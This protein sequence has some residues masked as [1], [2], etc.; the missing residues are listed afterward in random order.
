MLPK[1]L[2]L[3][4]AGI[5]CDEELAHGFRMAGAD[6]DIVHINQLVR[7]EKSIHDFDI[8]GF[9][10]GFAYGD[11]LS[12]GRV[13][14]TEVAAHL[15]DD[16]LDFYKNGGLIIGI[17][18]GFQTLVKA[19][20]LPRLPDIPDRSESARPTEATLFWN[21]SGKFEDRWVT[22]R[23]EPHTKCVWTKGLPR[24][25]EYPV[26]HAEGKF[27]PASDE[28][29]ESLS[30]SGQ[31]VFRYCDPASP[32]ACESGLVPYPLN[33][34][35][36]TANIAGICDPTGRILGLMPHPERFLYPENH[37]RHTRARTDAKSLRTA[38]PVGV[39]KSNGRADGLPLLKN[40][41]DYIRTEKNIPASR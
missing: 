40:A 24:M 10:G 6:A 36:S 22:L 41:V 15:M 30:A 7:K 8:I 21:A 37:P 13:L 14:A 25:I 39:G 33:P 31:I 17:C 20:I 5:N 11:D 35:G 18:N 32:D 28:V 29:L 9:P 19:G 2:I 26:A 12:A 27:I 38:A 3:K 16:L 34:N 23:I 1:T 4:T